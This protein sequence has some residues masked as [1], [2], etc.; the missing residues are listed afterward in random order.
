MI[1]AA[2]PWECSRTRRRSTIDELSDDRRGRGEQFRAQG[3]ADVDHAGVRARRRLRGGRTRPVRR[4]PCGKWLFNFSAGAD[5]TEPELF[6]SDRL[7]ARVSSTRWSVLQQLRWLRERSWPNRRRR[8]R[9]AYGP[10]KYDRLSRIKT[11]TTPTTS[12]TST[13]TSSR[14]CLVALADARRSG[15]GMGVS[16]VATLRCARRL[17]LR[18]TTRVS[19][20]RAFRRV[21]SCSCRR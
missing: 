17:R 13:P 1:D 8:V 7:G 16:R 9:T 6:A 15:R 4:E 14:S 11:N 3:V 20:V 5:V 2:A 12:S 21:L 18:E 19:V 10:A